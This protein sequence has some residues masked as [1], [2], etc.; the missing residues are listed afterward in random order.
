MSTG[1]LT[2]LIES[3]K[4]EEDAPRNYIGASSIG[5]DCLR[6][7][8]Y[9]YTGAECSAVPNKLR[10]TWDIGKHLEGLVLEWIKNAG[11]ELL[12]YQVKFSDNILSYFQGSCDAIMLNQDGILEIKTAKDASFKVFVRDGCRKWNPKYY[13]QLQAY[14]GM[15]G[16]TS[17]YI[18]VLNKDNSDLFDE[19]VKFDAEFYEKL[20]EKARLIHEAKSPPPRINGSPMFYFCKMCKFNKV[21]HK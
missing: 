19:L 9:E 18:L 7:I 15:S 14:M 5:S 10:R 21:C 20:K 4:H 1:K 16:I 3:L 6:Q 11:I 12:D 13:A 2:K 17:A 8:W